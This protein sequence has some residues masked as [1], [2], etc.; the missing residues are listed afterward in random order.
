MAGS[1]PLPRPTRGPGALPR[2]LWGDQGQPSPAR[3]SS[4]R[5][6]YPSTRGFST[7]HPTTTTMPTKGKAGARAH[8]FLRV[9]TLISNH[10][11]LLWGHKFLIIVWSVVREGSVPCHSHEPSS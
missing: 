3:F 8:W 10:F 5:H 6:C 1:P 9:E 11:E 4:D 2:R 7:S